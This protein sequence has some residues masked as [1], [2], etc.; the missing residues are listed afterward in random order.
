MTIV[1]LTLESTAGPAQVMSVTLRVNDDD[2]VRAIERAHAFVA[3]HVTSV[4]VRSVT[5]ERRPDD[6][7]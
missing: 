5:A 3:G 7:H 2:A 4:P 6:G 1:T